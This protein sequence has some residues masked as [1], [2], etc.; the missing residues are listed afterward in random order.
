MFSLILILFCEE[1]FHLDFDVYLWK[2]CG[3]QLCSFSLN[4]MYFEIKRTENSIENMISM[5]LWPTKWGIT[6]VIWNLWHPQTRFCWSNLGSFKYNKI[7]DKFANQKLNRGFFSRRLPRFL[8]VWHTTL[9]Q[10]LSDVLNVQITLDE[11][12][13]NVVCHLGG[14]RFSKNKAFNCEFVHENRV[15]HRL[16]KNLLWAMFRSILK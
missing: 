13:N 3:N 4:I 11:R 15:T 2:I 5:W 12:W 10:R 14:Y 6:N 9:L 7:C 1:E 16:H 8:V